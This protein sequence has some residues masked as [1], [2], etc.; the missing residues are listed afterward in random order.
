[1][2]VNMNQTGTAFSAN[3]ISITVKLVDG[4]ILDGKI[5]ILPH[6]RLSDFV[7]S[8]DKDFVVVIEGSSIDIKDKTVFINKNKVAWVEPNE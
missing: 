4:T 3:Y 2:G 7:N 1:M 6:K 8:S 5:N